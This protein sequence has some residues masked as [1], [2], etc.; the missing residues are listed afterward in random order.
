MRHHHKLAYGNTPEELEV[1][2]KKIFKDNSITESGQYKYWEK[3]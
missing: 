3:V 2:K 1:D